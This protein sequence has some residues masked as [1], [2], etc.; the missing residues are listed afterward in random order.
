MEVNFESF[1]NMLAATREVQKLTYAWFSA[2]EM[3]R[4]TVMSIE[5]GGNYRMSSLFRYVHLMRCEIMLNNKVVKDYKELGPK[6]RLLRERFH[7][8]RVEM[9]KL[10]GLSMNA[11]NQIERGGDFTRSTFAKYGSRLGCFLTLMVPIGVPSPFTS[12]RYSNLG[13]YVVEH[14]E[15]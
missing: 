7:V 4:K 6:F 9:S 13:D 2:H 14:G 8:N 15:E 5:H 10:T 11:L 3:S 12:K 1:E